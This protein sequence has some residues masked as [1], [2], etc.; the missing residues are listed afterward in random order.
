MI[1]P[2]ELSWEQQSAAESHAFTSIHHPHGCHN[3]TDNSLRNHRGKARRAVAH[4]HYVNSLSLLRMV[5]RNHI[6]PQRLRCKN[7]R[8][9]MSLLAAGDDTR[10]FHL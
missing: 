7:P 6:C 5:A 8:L 4:F 1:R 2:Q 10:V 3:F 9:I